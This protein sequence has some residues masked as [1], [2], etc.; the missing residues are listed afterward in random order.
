[1]FEAIAPWIPLL[2]PAFLLLDFVVQKRR[3]SK[4]RFWRARALIVTVAIF[5]WAGEVATFW[6]GV[7]GDFH[8]FDLSGLGPYAGAAVG[9]VVYEFLHYGYH[10]AVHAFDPLWRGFGHQMHHSAESLDAFG[11]HYLHPIDAAMFTTWGSLV[12]IPLLGLPFEAAIIGAVFLTFNGMFQ[13]ANIATPHWLGYLIQRPE[14][15]HIHHAQG[16][17]RYNYA[18]LPIIDMLFGTFRNP[19]TLEEGDCGFYTGASTRIFDM[20]LGRDVTE[21]AEPR[22]PAGTVTTSA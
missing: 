21:P 19:R 22:R 9:I 20:L 4:P 8:L 3:Y 10:R 18:D 1:M 7:F 15:H 12:F 6:G 13:H 2:I 5:F 14:S 11:A 16:V 17:H